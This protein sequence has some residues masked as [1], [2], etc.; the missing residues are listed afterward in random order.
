MVV[1]FFF[2]F[3]GRV[4]VGVWIEGKHQYTRK[5]IFIVRAAV[6]SFHLFLSKEMPSHVSDNG[7][8]ESNVS[9]NRNF[10]SCLLLVGTLP[11]CHPLWLC[12]NPKQ[13]PSL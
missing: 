13:I 4:F 11:H 12:V 9:D 10:E 8:Y 2:G 1:V 7:D 3:I 6:T 5:F